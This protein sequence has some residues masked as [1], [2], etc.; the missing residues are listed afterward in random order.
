[1]PILGTVASQFSSKPFG[2]YESIESVTVGAGGTASVTFSSIPA[3]YT[4]LQI[5]SIGRITAANS[6]DNIYMQ[7]NGDTASNYAGHYLFSDGSTTIPAA[8]GNQTQGVAARITGAS[9]G[10]SMFGVGICD[11][12][13]YRNTNKNK[14]VKVVTGHDKNGS[15]LIFLMSTLWQ[16]ASAITSIRLYTITDSFAQYSK[17]A[18]YG[19]KGE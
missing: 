1:M 16:S 17:L 12:L 10:A 5:R 2:S 11:I 18:L 13:D 6:D 14:T 4:H 15:G 8:A 19:I 9:S 7:F 3:T